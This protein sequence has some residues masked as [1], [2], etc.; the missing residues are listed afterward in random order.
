MVEVGD[1]AAEKVGAVP[2]GP[3]TIVQA[4]VPLVATLAAIVMSVVAI[5]LH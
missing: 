3:D 1:A 5:T 2:N 4:P